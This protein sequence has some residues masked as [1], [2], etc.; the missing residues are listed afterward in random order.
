MGRG[1]DGREDMLRSKTG[2]GFE[3]RVLDAAGD[4]LVKKKVML[5]LN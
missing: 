1:T 4:L 5:L 3:L 2:R